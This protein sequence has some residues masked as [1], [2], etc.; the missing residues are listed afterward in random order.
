MPD[1]SAAIGVVI[2]AWNAAPTIGRAIASALVQPEVAEVIVV[3]DASADETMA[4]ALAADDGSGRLRVLSQPVNAGPA[5][6]RNRAIAESGSP[7]LAILDADDFLL[8]GR[9]A[10]ILAARD[11]DV[12]ADN[13]AFVPASALATFDPA[14]IPRFAPEARMIG[15][16]AFVEGNIPRAGAPRGELGFVKPVIR[17]AILDATCLRYDE[18]LRLGEDY[19]LYARLLARGARFVLQRTCGYVA[20]ERANS[21]S[22]QHGTADLRALLAAN[23]AL[24]AEEQLPA[25]SRVALDRH[26]ARLAGRL[27]HREMLDLRRQRGRLRAAASAFADPARLPGLV[28]AIA[29]DK[30]GG[31]ARPEA[32]KDIRYLF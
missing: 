25:D 18:T 31:T 16:G 3:D 29:R 13:I 32:V 14:S 12:C 24:A 4:A 9:F 5:A 6:A 2:A 23:A 7:L 20:V 27:Y 1:E 30:L 10:P 19:A 22:G 8:P 15:F 21:L 26:S 28:R 11:W 17:R